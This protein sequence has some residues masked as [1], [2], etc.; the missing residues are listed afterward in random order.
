MG[1]KEDCSREAK[2]DTAARISHRGSTRQLAG[3]SSF[4][5]WKRNTNV[6][7]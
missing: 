6:N 7:K 4:S 1:S 5:Y 2:L 3:L